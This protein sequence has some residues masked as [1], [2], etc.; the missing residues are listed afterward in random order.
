MEEQVMSLLSRFGKDS[1]GN[2][3]MLF[4]LAII[5]LLGAAGAA[6]DYARASSARA[7]LNAAV[8]SAAL[9]VARDATRLTD[10]QL[11]TRA[12]ALIRANLQG[13]SDAKLG[14]YSVSVNRTARTVSVKADTTVATSLTKIIGIDTIPVA[15][16]A[17]AGWGTNTIEVALVL[18]NTGSMDRSSKM[19]EL[20]KATNKFIDTMQASNATPSNI[21]V[22]IV[23]FETQVRLPLSYKDEDW[24]RFK[25]R[26][27]DPAYLVQKQDWQGCVADRDSPYDTSDASAAA[28]DAK[29]PATTC[30]TSVTRNTGLAELRPLT[31][32]WQNLR[33]TVTAMRPVGNTNVTVGI[34]WGLAALSRDAP[35]PEAADT[36]TPRLTKY[37]IVLTDGDNTDNR[38]TKDM[39]RGTN[40]AALIDPKTKAACDSAKAA[41]IKVYT[42]RVIDGNAGLLQ[43][44]AS[45]PDMYYNVKDAAGIGPVI[46]AIAREISAVRLTM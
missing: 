8:D 23:P 4:G 43:G 11:K 16:T 27:T 19:D 34:A 21:R 26:A 14:S 29:Y 12:E 30:A 44:C 35:L 18:D 41:G 1:S 24:M 10:A 37:M 6:V 7:T 33:D 20:K 22:S 42:I 28:L 15:S 2:V 3:A 32:N 40:K 38:F 17:Q 25:T 5:P 45:K 31:D 13:N 46:E 39:P 36:G 9:M